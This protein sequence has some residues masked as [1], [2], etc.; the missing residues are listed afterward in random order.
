M[1][2]ILT[3]K[4]QTA[5]EQDVWNYDDSNDPNVLVS[6][7]KDIVI[8]WT[9]TGYY[10]YQ[11][12]KV[13][14]NDCVNGHT[15]SLRKDGTTE[16]WKKFQD[17]FIDASET[18]LFRID[19]PIFR[20][21]HEIDNANWEYTK[22]ARPGAG[23]GTVDDQHFM[24]PQLIKQFMEDIIDPYYHAIETAIKV[25]KNNPPT[26]SPLPLTIPDISV[27]HILKDKQGY[28]FAKNFDLWDQDPGRVIEMCVGTCQMIMRDI[29]TATISQEFIDQWT[30][31]AVNKW[32]SLV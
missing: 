23:I 14:F 15:Y 18:K 25:A 7:F 10:Q 2:D 9:D 12:D 28:Y 19:A 6:P 4:L 16:D 31:T 26:N 24:N 17:L 32:T 5:I 8:E 22:A 1:L 11:K 13:M 21:V 27:R 20:Q 29:G 3:Q 30:V